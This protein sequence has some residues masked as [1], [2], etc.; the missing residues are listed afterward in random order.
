[1]SKTIG[2]VIGG[3]VLFLGIAITI[4]YFSTTNDEI[5]LRNTIS[6]KIE[7]SQSHYTKMW[8]ILTQQAG[9]SQ[10]YAD[11]FKEIY[12]ELIS[13]RYD[14]NNGQLMQWVQEHNPEFDTSLYKQLM[15]SIEGQRES[16]HTN[17]RQLIDYSRQHNNLIK[18]FPSRLFLAS[19]EP[20][21]IPVIINDKAVKAFGS[22]R[23]QEM[24][25]FRK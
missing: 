17:Q 18:T 8:E 15:V 6:A 13:G 5:R 9:V 11:D 16:F 14:N 10:Q 7:D 24:V 25:L 20:I 12:P 4:A 21:D 1:M 23:E 19:V 3:I 22:E 2:I